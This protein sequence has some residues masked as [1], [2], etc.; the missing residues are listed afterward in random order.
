VSDTEHAGRRNTRLTLEALRSAS[1]VDEG[2]H[3][4]ESDDDNW[5]PIL[6]RWGE[7][8]TS[9]SREFYRGKQVTSE[10]THMLKVV[11][12]KEL[13]SKLLAT[14]ASKRR[15]RIGTGPSARKLNIAG[16]PYNVDEQD[17]F[18]MFPCVESR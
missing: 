3:V 6:S 16:P 2:G 13:A 10:L 1:T 18:I 7:V 11:F 4:V 12:D 9:Q 14:N 5:T 15:I 8:H 17:E